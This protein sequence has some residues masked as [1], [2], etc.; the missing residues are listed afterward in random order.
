MR[1]K[2]KSKII[3]NKGTL[4]IYNKYFADE[5]FEFSHDKPGLLSMTNNGPDTNGSSFFIT[6]S[7]CKWLDKK[8]V[9][10]G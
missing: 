9:V 2:V 8:N 10:F 4:S 5:S 3:F 1:K 7:P 6:L